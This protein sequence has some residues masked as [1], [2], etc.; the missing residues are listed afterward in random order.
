LAYVKQKIVEDAQG[1]KKLAQ[2]FRESQ[3]TAQKDPWAE[4]VAEPVAFTPLSV[5]KAEIA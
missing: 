1:R 5:L 2:A 4:C 3:L